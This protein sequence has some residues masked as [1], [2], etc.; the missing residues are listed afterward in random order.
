MG[1]ALGQLSPSLAQAML[2]ALG[3]TLGAFGYTLACPAGF[4]EAGTAPGTVAADASAAGAEVHLQAF[5]SDSLLPLSSASASAS[6]GGDTV[7]AA[8]LVNDGS[9]HEYAARLR[10]DQFGRGITNL[11]YQLTDN[12]SRPLEVTDR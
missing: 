10:G 1:A 9:R 4:S 3:P 5:P 8:V 6:A 7:P 2:H 11:R 12:D